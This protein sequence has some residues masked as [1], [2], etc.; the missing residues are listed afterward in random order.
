[1]PG[2]LLFRVAHGER[3]A[4]GD[5]M[6]CY[7]GLVWSLARRFCSSGADAEDAVQEVFIDLW[8]NAGRFD[9]A[10]ASEPTF[11]AMIARRRLIDR[12]RKQ[13]RRSATSPLASDLAAPGRDHLDEIEISDE[14]AFVAR[15]LAQLRPEE[16]QVLELSIYHGLSHSEIAARIDT[17]LG[18]VKTLVR[19][20]LIRL[21]GLLAAQMPNLAQDSI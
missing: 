16:Q 7:G 20:G 15:H 3:D 9:P 13:G 14:A 5:F 12:R 21:R 1:M 10:V 8:R 18:T 11:V 17:A 6:N 4:V 2:P 19:R